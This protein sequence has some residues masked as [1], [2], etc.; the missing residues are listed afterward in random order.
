VILNLLEGTFA[1][2]SVN[3]TITLNA[4]FAGDKIIIEILSSQ[5]MLKKSQQEEVEKMCGEEELS[6][7]LESPLIDTNT[8]I[9]FMIARQIGWP[10]DF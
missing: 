4:R 8:K 9:A 1:S 7:I 3:S 2:G 5:T 10:V 6:I